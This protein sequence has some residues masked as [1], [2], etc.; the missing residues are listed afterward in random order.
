MDREADPHTQ[1]MIDEAILDYLC[2]TAIEALLSAHEAETQSE[3]NAQRPLQM[4][5]A[6]LSIFRTLHPGHHAPA[7]IEFRLRLLQ[8]SCLFKH[9]RRFLTTSP[10][11]TRTRSRQDLHAKAGTYSKSTAFPVEQTGQIYL[12]ETLPLFLAL[13]AVQNSL[14][15]STITELWMRLAA[16]YMAHAYAEQVLSLHETQPG[17]LEEIFHWSFDPSQ[18]A[19][20]GSDERMINEMFHANKDIIGL[21][22]DIKG[23]HVRAVSPCV[24]EWS[25]LIYKPAAP[26]ARRNLPHCT[27]ESNGLQQPL[28]LR[29]QR[30]NLRIP[31]RSS[32]RSSSAIADSARE[33]QD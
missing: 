32:F 19:E 14:Q 33:R 26:T 29:F 3:D 10:C 8:F 13:S 9:R 25:Q 21:W 27:S 16:G 6:F 4:V 2:F 18:A 11:L 1:L 7:E 24:C 31:F 5:G 17:L 15:E 28:S 23:E 12:K 30:K 22:E 20:Q